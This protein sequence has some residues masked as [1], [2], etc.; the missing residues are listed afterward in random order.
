M[1]NISKV[2]QTLPNLRKN[3]TCQASFS[4]VYLMKDDLNDEVPNGTPRLR[5]LS[6]EVQFE[7]FICR[8][9]NGREA[10]EVNVICNRWK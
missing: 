6:H 9:Y 5:D 2:I 3:S 8:G 4:K 7:M 1:N 10:N